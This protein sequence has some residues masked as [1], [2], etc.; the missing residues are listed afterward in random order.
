MARSSKR[1]SA[2]GGRVWLLSSLFV[3]VGTGWAL[4]VPLFHPP[5]EPMHVDLIGGL[6]DDPTYP[7]YADRHLDRLLLSLSWSYLE[8]GDGP[9]RPRLGGLPPPAGAASAAQVPGGSG[10][11]SQI[12]QMPQHPPLYYEGAALA[13]RAAR[14]G[15]PGAPFPTIATEV[16]VLRLLNVLLV[17]PLPLLTFRIAREL[18]ASDRTSLTA[19]ALLLAVPQLTHI[20]GSV[21]NDNLLIVLGAA[22]TLLVLQVVGRP[23]D[24]RRDLAVGLVLG[25][26]LLTKAFA[27]VLVPWV[28]LAYLVAARRR[29]SPGAA[30][31]G[32]AVAGGTS[33]AVA[34]WFWIRNV[35][36]YGQVAP[37]T[38]FERAGTRPADLPVDHLDWLRSFTWLLP[39]RFWGSMGRYAAQLPEEVIALATLLVAACVAEALVARRRPEA[40]DRTALAMAV[41]PALMLGAYVA[42]HAHEIYVV[43]GWYSFIQGRYLFGGIGG[44]LAVTAVGA[45]R[46]AR[47]RFGPAAALGVGVAM[48][49]IAG[50][51]LLVDVWGGAGVSL[52]GSARTMVAWCPLPAPAVGAVGLA[53]AAVLATTAVSLTRAVPEPRPADV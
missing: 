30:A 49:V 35:A 37:T 46:L 19:T 33:A 24:R 10:P 29:G 39:E 53:L 8:A 50:Y 38:F 20:V 43:T 36:R 23:P 42:Q 26:A 16:L 51:V 25:A 2:V 34:G 45:D 3:L 47:G 52:L 41:L 22:L 18:G 14:F 6:A 32:L 40:R 7:G 27:F 17:A 48:Q 28:A 5:D 44:L 13:L 21:N 15:H 1:R 11:S 9:R 31:G 12:D 4:A